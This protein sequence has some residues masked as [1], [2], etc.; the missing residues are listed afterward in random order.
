[1]EEL[2]KVLNK[3]INYVFDIFLNKLD[4]P[5]MPIT[6]VKVLQQGIVRSGRRMRLIGKLL[7]IFKLE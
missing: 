3:D 2:A 6:D 1:M 5:K 7:C 4:D